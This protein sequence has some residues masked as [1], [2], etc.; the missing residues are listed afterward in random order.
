[1]SDDQQFHAMGDHNLPHES[2]HLPR[3]E[4]PCMHAVYTEKP[5]VVKN[6]QRDMRFAK[7]PD[8][9]DLGVKFY[10]GFP[11]RAPSGEVVGNLCAIV[12]SAHKRHHRNPDQARLR[13]ASTLVV[14]GPDFMYVLNP[15]KN[16]FSK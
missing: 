4:V 13:P 1:M 16:S 7:M 12:S 9:A 6:P 2:H 10:A 11:L 3:Q 14:W 5:L 8:V 15:P